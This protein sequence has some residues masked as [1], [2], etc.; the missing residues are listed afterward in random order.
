MFK[1]PWLPEVEP[2]SLGSGDKW[3][4]LSFSLC[5]FA[6]PA[7]DLLHSPRSTKYLEEIGEFLTRAVVWASRL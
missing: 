2:L 3:G 6:S 7:P 5:P 1:V 4:F